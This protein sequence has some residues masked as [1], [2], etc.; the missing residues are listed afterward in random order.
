M[1]FYFFQWTE[2]IIEHLA[3]HGVSQDEFEAIVC[4]PDTRSTSRSSGLP[5]AFGETDDGRFLA[6]VYELEHNTTAIPITAYEVE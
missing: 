3:E 2:E 1:P 5:I 6:C 4:S